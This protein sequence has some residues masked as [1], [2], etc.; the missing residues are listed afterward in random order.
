MAYYEKQHFAAIESISG[1]DLTTPQSH[2]NALSQR[3]WNMFF[4]HNVSIL[5]RSLEGWSPHDLRNGLSL[6]NLTTLQEYFELTEPLEDT[7]ART[8]HLVIYEEIIEHTWDMGCL[9][10][11]ALPCI[12]V[13]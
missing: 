6:R 7:A 1:G 11:T 12:Q 3:D 13:L 4:K 5:T 8:S 2:V 10:A 9:W